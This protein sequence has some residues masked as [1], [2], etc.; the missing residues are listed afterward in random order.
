[1]WQAKVELA[2]VVDIAES[3]PPGYYTLK[4]L[5]GAGW[6]H[7][8]RKPHVGKLFKRW[9]DG[10]WIPHVQWVRKRS[11]RSHEYEVNVS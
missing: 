2:D 10:G 9:V 11:D 8:L 7:V 1:M 6:K 4:Q 5:Y 3:F